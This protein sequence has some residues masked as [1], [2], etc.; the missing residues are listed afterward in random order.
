MPF[1]TIVRFIKGAVCLCEL[2]LMSSWKQQEPDRNLFQ[3]L[4]WGVKWSH[5][6]FFQMQKTYPFSSAKT[7]TG[8]DARKSLLQRKNAATMVVQ[9]VFVNVA[10][11]E[12]KVSWW[13]TVLWTSLKRLHDWLLPQQFHN[14]H[15]DTHTHLHS[16]PCREHSD[17]CALLYSIRALLYRSTVATVVQ[18]NAT[19]L[20]VFLYIYAYTCTCICLCVYGSRLPSYHLWKASHRYHFAIT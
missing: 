5:I 10:C 7:I 20:F 17:F 11:W 13:I 8:N 18:W 2:F 4:I 6:C 14:T 16:V 3:D 15:S 9:C 19:I 1:K 12:K